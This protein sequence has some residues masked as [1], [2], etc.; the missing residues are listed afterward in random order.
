MQIAVWV[1][2]GAGMDQSERD[3]LARRIIEKFDLP[4]TATYQDTCRRVGEVLS[5]FLQ[6]NVEL[7]FVHMRSTGLSGATALLRDGTYVVYCVRS[8]S[9]YHRLGILLHELA[10]VF[11]GHDPVTLEPGAGLRQ[12]APNLPGRMARIIAGRTSHAQHEEREAEE[13]ADDLLERLTAEPRGNDEMLSSE[14]APYVIRIAEELAPPPMRR[15]D[16]RG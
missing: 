3:D 9:W 16:E 10:H 7:R 8:R 1:R 4:P 13:L 14:V 11:L 6:A 5:E 2:E 12:F 15:P